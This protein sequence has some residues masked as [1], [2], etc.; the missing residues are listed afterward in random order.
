[1]S[2]GVDRRSVELFSCSAESNSTNSDGD[3]EAVSNDYLALVGSERRE[4]KPIQGNQTG[5]P[6]KV[7][8]VCLYTLALRA[9]GNEPASDLVNEC[10]C[11]AARSLARSSLAGSIPASTCCG[12]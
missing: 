11:A 6:C 10:Y 7:F 8:V 5:G 1:M 2:T 9:A 12:P 3:R 4:E